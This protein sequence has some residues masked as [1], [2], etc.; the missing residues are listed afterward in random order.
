[1][2]FFPLSSILWVLVIQ[3]IQKTLHAPTQRCLE[4]GAPQ[5][6][7]RHCNVLP[8]IVIA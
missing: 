2:K 1:M 4:G 5:Y 8:C 3:R 7:C 6:L